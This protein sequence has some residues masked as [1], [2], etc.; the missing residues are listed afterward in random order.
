MQGNRH[1]Y[2]YIYHDKEIHINTMYIANFQYNANL[3]A[4]QAGCPSQY[5]WTMK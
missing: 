5:T 3:L 1:K 4:P 2:I